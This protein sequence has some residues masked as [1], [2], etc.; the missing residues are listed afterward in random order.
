[1]TERKS[2]QPQ[3]EIKINYKVMV[4]MI[5]IV[6]VLAWILGTTFRHYPSLAGVI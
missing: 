5:T 2:L 6:V 1:M 3:K 4:L